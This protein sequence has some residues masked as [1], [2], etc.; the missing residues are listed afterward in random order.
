[1]SFPVHVSA[2]QR[3]YHSGTGAAIS[4]MFGPR[5]HHSR[6]LESAKHFPMQIDAQSAS[7][8]WTGQE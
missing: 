7:I 2:E 6:L 5:R 8:D 1:M 4:S 3:N